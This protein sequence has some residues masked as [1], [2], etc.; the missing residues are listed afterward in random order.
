[1]EILK[2]L[3][4]GAEILLLDEP[5]A[6][7]APPEAD[8]LFALLHTLVAEGKTVVF[9][10]HKLREVM[11]HSDAVTVLRGG[12]SVAHFRT[13]DTNEQELLRA[14]LS[15]STESQ[16]LGAEEQTARRSSAIQES[17][18][19]RERIDSALESQHSTLLCIEGLTVRNAR[20]VVAVNNVTLEVG[21]GEIVGVAGVDG[22]GQRELSEALVGLRN[23]DSGRIALNDEDVTRRSVRARQRIGIGYIPEDR[24]R[25]GMVMDFSIAENYLLGHESDAE[26]GGGIMLKRAKLIDRAKAMIRAYDVRGGERGPSL[27]AKSLSGGNQQKVVIARAMDGKPK[28]LVACQP[29]RGLDVEASRFVY[30]T[31]RA[32]RDKGLGILLFSL[33][34]DEIFALSGRIAVLYNGTLAGVL[35][36]RDA[37]PDNVGALMTSGNLPASSFLLP[38]SSLPGGVE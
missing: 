36:R 25:A 8:A 14:M 3:Y 22:S 27:A 28:L 4:R 35:P 29:T 17:A 15:R 1:M 13:S 18:P 37:N 7:L 21:A 34:L 6:T 23:V 12:K 24:H 19:S 26:W 9:V 38:P 10:T 32:A 5:T 30:E 31:L 20:R 2:A 33:D 16:K 11:T